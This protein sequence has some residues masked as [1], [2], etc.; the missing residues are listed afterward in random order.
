MQVTD[1]P[2]DDRNRESTHHG[3]S[4]F[5]LAAYYSVMSKNILGYTRPHWHEEIQFCLVV[6]GAIEFHVEQQSYHL[7]TGD[8]IFINS[9]YLHMARPVSD[10]DSTY[11]CL[12]AG[13]Q[14]LS[15]FSGS[16]ME[17]M[18]VLPALQD[19]SLSHMVLRRDIPWQQEALSHIKQLYSY[20]CQHQTA[21]E[22]EVTAHLQLLFVSIL[23]HRP[24]SSRPGRASRRSVVVQHIISYIHQHYQEPVRLCD[25]AAYST[26]A[27]SECCRIFKKFT[28]ESIFS[29]LRTFR[30]EQSTWL[31]KNSNQPV[32]DIA[33][34]CGFSS[35]SYFIEMFRQQFAMTPLKY[36]LKERA[37]A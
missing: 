15:G 22:M 29:Y 16:L 10:P 6:Q 24:D 19:P 35:A 26:Y 27:E 21:Y 3:N 20:I 11:I 18:Y 13:V 14:L 32:S 36:R 31:L 2:V 17:K 25:I 4:A 5:P 8:G 12:D 23:R 9:G 1:I 34:A 37:D 33:Y 28:G 7:R 30:L